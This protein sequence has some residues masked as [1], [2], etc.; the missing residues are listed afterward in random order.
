[1]KTLTVPRLELCAALLG[2]QLT[3]QTVE[4]TSTGVPIYFWS[5]SK[6]VLCW[7]RKTPNQLQT[8]MSNR[9]VKIQSLTDINNWYYV[10][11]KENPADITSRGI[12]LENLSN[13]SLWWDGPK[14]FYKPI[15]A[16]LPNENLTD[17][18]IPEL[19]KLTI[20]FVS[21]ENVQFNLFAKYSNPKTLKIVVAY[22]FRFMSNTRKPIPQER[23]CG[24]LTPTEVQTSF[25]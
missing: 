1:M 15:E 20:I 5:D 21:T 19:K 14:F 13:C 4:A 9:V 22:C 8:F 3:Q 7:I 18:D 16:T 23:I 25:L 2:S 6:I 11:T 24:P 10:K 12:L 17:C